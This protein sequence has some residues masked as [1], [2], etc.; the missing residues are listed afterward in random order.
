MVV[1]AA[2]RN[3]FAALAFLLVLLVGKCKVDTKEKE[4]ER[5]GF[6]QKEF[7]ME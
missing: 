4:R 7:W 3:L 1:K 6:F 5:A 2:R